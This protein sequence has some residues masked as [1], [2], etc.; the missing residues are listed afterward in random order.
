MRLP[1]AVAP[2]R[3]PPSQLPSRCRAL[4]R[5]VARGGSRAIRRC[6]AG[7]G[8]DPWPPGRS[9][10]PVASRCSSIDTVVG[11]E[12]AT[13]GGLREW[14]AFVADS[15]GRS[16][17]ASAVASG[18]GAAAFGGSPEPAAAG[19]SPRTGGAHRSGCRWR[20]GDRR[21]PRTRP[22]G[23]VAKHRGL[24]ADRR[25]LASRRTTGVEIGGAPASPRLLCRRTPPRCEPTPRRQRQA[26]RRTICPGAN[27]RR[28]T[29][30][31]EP[32]WERGRRP[33]RTSESTVPAG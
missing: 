23:D 33:D 27:R 4:Q 24:A 10:G 14:S 12:L 22:A 6:A 29:A 25:S 32:E 20:P 8:R 2:A 30:R 15:A 9:R 7:A 5:R 1:C 28:Q 31:R 13:S 19:P 11:R 16:G 21:G 18:G 17:V 3:S 26:G